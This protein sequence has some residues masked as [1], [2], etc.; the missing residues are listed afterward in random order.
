[1]AAIAAIV[2]LA[3]I[4]RLLIAPWSND[5]NSTGTSVSGA[6][7]VTAPY[8]GGHEE[9][10]AG[11]QSTPAQGYYGGHEEGAMSWEQGRG[12]RLRAYLDPHDAFEAVGLRE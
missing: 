6:S 9:G 5:S 2:V 7:Q 3:A 11:Q 8:N 4:A 10:V 1:M 12:W